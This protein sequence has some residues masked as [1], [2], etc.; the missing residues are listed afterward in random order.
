VSS[1]ATA[2]QDDD[3]SEICPTCNGRGSMPAKSESSA[4]AADQDQTIGWQFCEDCN[5]TGRKPFDGDV[6]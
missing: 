2:S 1:V 3:E 6:D 5:G 4:R